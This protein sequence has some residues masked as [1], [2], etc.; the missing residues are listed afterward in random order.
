MKRTLGLA[1]MAVLMVSGCSSEPLM[2]WKV[3]RVQGNK[4]ASCY[5]DNVITDR[6]STES[7]IE[8]YAGEWEMY[9]AGGDTFLLH[10]GDVSGTVLAGMKK[11]DGYSFEGLRTVKEV[12]AGTVA[13]PT[14]TLFAS[15]GETVTLT[16]NGDTFTGTW[17][18][19]TTKWCEGTCPASY[20]ID[21]PSCTIEDSLKGTRIPVQTYHAE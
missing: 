16:L 15:T 11:G 9:K 17:K 19:T 18:H 7:S 5:K 8:E 10:L 13:A 2:I 12:T 1:L 21:N 6:K 14:T 3:S 20:A 4:P